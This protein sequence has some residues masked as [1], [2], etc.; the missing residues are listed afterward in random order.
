MP[1]RWAANMLTSP[2]PNAGLKTKRILGID[3][4]D[5]TSADAIAWLSQNG[6]L[7]V[8]PA[9]PSLIA[10]QRDPDYRRAIADADLAIADSGW[11]VL[12]WKLLKGETVTRISGLKLFQELLAS[13]ES[14]HPQNIF[15]VV[16]SESGKTKA[17][18]FGQSS[19][20]P[21]TAA[22]CYV[23]PLYPKSGELRDDALLALLEVRRPKHVIICVGGGMQDK[24]GSWLKHHLVYRPAIYCIGA[25]PG[26]VTGDQVQIPMWA[27]RFFVGWIF[28]IIA[29]PRVFIPRFWSVRRLPWLI[30]KYGREMPVAAKEESRK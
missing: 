26:F 10:L 25:A 9:A 22:D 21:I 1:A 19:A 30:V 13:K 7:V 29:Q 2:V 23:A 11:M 14:R 24:L 27:D 15:W 12:F 3:F 5:E 28:R 16:P 17:L 18:A 20:Y 4:F 6:G 8:A